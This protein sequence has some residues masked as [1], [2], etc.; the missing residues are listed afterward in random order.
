MGIFEKRRFRS[1][2]Q[3]VQ[4]F[5]VNEQK[6]WKNFDCKNETMAKCFEK[7]GLDAN[8]AEFSGHALALHRDDKYELFSSLLSV[9]VVQYIL[10]NNFF[11][12]IPSTVEPHC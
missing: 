10:L 1:F 8:T 7:F 5:D 11:S 3:F 6:T 4:D 2:L 12:E 9:T